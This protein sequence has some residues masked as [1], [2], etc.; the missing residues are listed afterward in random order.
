M[1]P[2][3]WFNIQQWGKD[4][5]LTGGPRV[6]GAGGIDIDARSYTGGEAGLV[7]SLVLLGGTPLLK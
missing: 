1:K 3:G 2:K 5:K 7:V 4:D 6:G